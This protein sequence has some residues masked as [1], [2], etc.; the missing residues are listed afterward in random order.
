MQNFYRKVQNWLYHSFI[1]LVS[2]YVCYHKSSCVH[3]CL[4]VYFC[5]SVFVCVWMVKK[6]L[7][8]MFVWCSDLWISQPVATLLPAL[9]LCS[10][11]ASPSPL[12]G[13]LGV[14]LC[15]LL[16]ELERLIFLRSCLSP[17]GL[18]AMGCGCGPELPTPDTSLLSGG[19]A[20]PSLSQSGH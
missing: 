7:K 11:Q 6:S 3:V 1:N 12:R 17:F 10:Q 13:G 20:A 4:Y 16:L 18:V 9:D 15:K 2:D 8:S 5:Y 14:W 19:V